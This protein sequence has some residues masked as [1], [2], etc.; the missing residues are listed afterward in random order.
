[1]LILSPTKAKA[2]ELLK[3]SKNHENAFMRED[4]DYLASLLAATQP[5]HQ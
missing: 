5:L 1:M 2:L 4:L 3:D